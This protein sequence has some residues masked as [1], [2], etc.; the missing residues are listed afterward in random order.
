[1]SKPEIRK[2][3]S[4]HDVGAATDLIRELFGVFIS[5]H[6]EMADSIRGYMQ[7]QNVEGELSDFKA[8]YNPP[9]GEAFM[10]AVGDQRVGICL[11]KPH[12]DNGAELNRMYVR[13]EA[14]GLGIGR[15]L[16]QAVVD[17]ARVLGKAYVYLESL[18]RNDA[19]LSL[20]RSL[21]FKDTLSKGYLPDD[22]RIVRMQIDFPAPLP[23]GTD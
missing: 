4:D 6:P 5:T 8:I 1:M 13:P 23:Q 9:K 2:V 12:G 10:A 7:H 20:Y 14:Q 15:A 17:E 19:A 18:P 16:C 11:L 22:D 3:R 21:G